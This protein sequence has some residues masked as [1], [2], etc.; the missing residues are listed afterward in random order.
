MQL[1]SSVERPPSWPARPTVTFSEVRSLTTRTSFDN[2]VAHVMGDIPMLRCSARV[3]ALVLALVFVSFLA[4]PASASPLVD[5]LIDD[6]NAFSSDPDLQGS[7]TIMTPT[8]SHVEGLGTLV[9]EDGTSLILTYDG[10]LDED[11]FAEGDTLQIAI[12]AV[13][14]TDPINL[15]VAFEDGDGIAPLSAN[16]DVL[17]TA[18]G[19][20]ELVLMSTFPGIDFTDIE[21]LILTFTSTG[22]PGTNFDITLDEVSVVPE[23][24][25]AALLALGLIGLGF[26]GRRT[27]LAS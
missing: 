16:H 3:S 11:F 15:N 25:S 4:G 12:S 13:S 14:F 8:G 22:M 7:R 20:V 21:K 5:G 18:Q 10:G 2:V 26:A 9:Y 17:I 6:F 24:S 27:E 1:S 19:D 23:P